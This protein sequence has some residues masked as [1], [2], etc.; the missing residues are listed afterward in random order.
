MTPRGVYTPLPIIACP[1]DYC[2]GHLYT[3]LRIV[4]CP[5]H[6]MASTLEGMR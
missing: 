5:L 2:K 6:A 1:L 3:P 4:A